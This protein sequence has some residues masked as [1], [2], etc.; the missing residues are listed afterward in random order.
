MT[1]PKPIFTCKSIN[2]FGVHQKM[3]IYGPDY[4]AKY[5]LR[6]W[7]H[8]ESCCYSA[9]LPLDTLINALRA[10]YTLETNL[11]FDEVVTLLTAHKNERFD[12]YANS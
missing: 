8:N 3:V 4:E 6:L 1:T 10:N 12:P 11:N 5:W 9:D 2:R 7:N